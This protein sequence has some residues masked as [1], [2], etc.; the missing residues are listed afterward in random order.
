MGPSPAFRGW[1]SE[2]RTIRDDRFCA[3]ID[4]EPPGDTKEITLAELVEMRGKPGISDTIVLINRSD[5]DE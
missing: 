3:T 1:Q 5:G 4:I 2:E